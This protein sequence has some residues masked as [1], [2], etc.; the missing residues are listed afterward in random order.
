MARLYTRTG[1]AGTTGLMGGPRV[2]KDHLRIRALGD[3]DEANA[4]IGLAL[5]FQTDG[6]ISAVLREA[7]NALFTVGAEVG[8]KPKAKV[9]RITKDHVGALESAI[10]AI[11]VG[12]IR[13][14]VMPR[15]PPSVAALHFA[16]TVVR[17]AERSCVAL[18]KREKLNPELLRYLNRL[19]SYLFQAAVW[20]QQRERLPEEHPTYRR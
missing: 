16:R 10:A 19:S 5:A 17:R 13:E 7:Q 18:S 12:E 4:A 6:P 15:G 14:F 20:V 1:D 11:D 8:S 2:S 9:P 3:V